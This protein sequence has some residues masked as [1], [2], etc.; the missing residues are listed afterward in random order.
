MSQEDLAGR[1][2]S[3]YE[4]L[5][6]GTIDVDLLAPDFELIQGAIIDSAGYFRGREAVQE[7]LEEVRSSF[8]ELRF[9]PEE[10]IDAGDGRLLV[11]VRSTGRGKGSGMPVDD[12]IAHL[13]TFRDGLA[14]RLEIYEEQ[15]EAL[16]A[17]GLEE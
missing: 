16:K 14:I 5:S 15:D 13:W 10:I 11:L 12:H 7:A 8:D 1:L 6:S 2:R 9:T 4:L 3:G 17:V